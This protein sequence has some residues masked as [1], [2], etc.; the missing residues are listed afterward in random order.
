VGLK[1]FRNEEKEKSDELRR[2]TGFTDARAGDACDKTQKYVLSLVD[3]IGIVNLNPAA[4]KYYTQVKDYNKRWEDG[5]FRDW[6][7]YWKTTD[8]RL[9]EGRELWKLKP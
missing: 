3:K 2:K 4:R 8:D 9:K 5:E 7:D 6:R 1:V